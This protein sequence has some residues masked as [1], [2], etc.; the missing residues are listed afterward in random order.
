MATEPQNAPKGPPGNVHG[1]QVPVSG[2]LPVEPS[3]TPPAPSR[4]ATF[5]MDS[6]GISQ[7][8][9]LHNDTDIVYL[10]ATVGAGNPVPLQ[11]SM[12][13][14]NNGT[15]SVGLSVEVDIPDDDTIVVFSIMI[16]NAGHGGSDAEDKAAQS[17]LSTIAKEIIKHGALTAGAVT[18]GSVVVPFFDSALLALSGILA[19]QELSLLLFGGCDGPVAHCTYPFTCSDLIRRTNSGQK[20]PQITEHRGTK[21][22]GYCNSSDLRYS[23]TCT[24]TTAPSIQTVLD[25]RGEWMGGGVA[26]QIISR[27]GNSISINMSALHR[28]TASGSVLDSTHISVHFPDDKTLT[29][30]LQAPNVIKWSNN[31]SWTKVVAIA[32]VIDLNGQWMSGGVLGPAIVVGGNSI[33]IDMSKLGR[34]NALGT[35]VNSS[36]I[37]VN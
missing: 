34:P 16:C 24:V 32:T 15:H 36:N 35:V 7:T 13:D 2:R 11:K 12:G 8:R 30:V 9:S 20:I 10:S 25:L 31:S 1:V 22:P 17:A 19:A 26:G 6:F 4:L 3:L 37:S 23:T 33:S 5:T 21:S 28:P 18:I 14:V 27:T 29:G